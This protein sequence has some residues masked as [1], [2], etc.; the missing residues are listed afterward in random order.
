MTTQ[1]LVS[2]IIPTYNRAHLIGETLDSVLEQ[3]YQ[4]W[5]CIVVDDGSTDTTEE[6]LKLYMVND[7][8]FQYHKRPEHLLGGGNAARNFGFE[9]ANGEYVQWFDDDDIMLEDYI[10]ARIHLFS[11]EVNMVLCTGYM[12]DDNLHNRTF[13]PIKLMNSIYKDYVLY[14]SKIMIESILFR[15]S[16]LMQQDR[17]FRTDITRAQES[18]LFL[19][20]FYTIQK[21]AYVILEIPLFLYRQHALN[22]ATKDEVY[23]KSFKRSRS[24]IYADNLKKCIALHD[25]KLVTIL[26]HNLLAYFFEGIKN[27][28]SAN[29]KWILKELIKDMRHVS[30]NLSMILWVLGF[31]SLLFNYPFYRFHK[32]LKFHSSLKTIS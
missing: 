6:V 28:H 22:K 26:Y 29:S 10:K 18:E 27:D 1:P 8:R 9:Q 32:M 12:V 13:L 2:I 23:N 20:L 7:T 17:L 3:T 11:A 31:T 30:S 24:I 4:N 16:H 15:K 19:R 5:E 14:T 21:D 25:Q